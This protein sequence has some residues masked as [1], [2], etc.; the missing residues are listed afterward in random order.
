MEEEEEEERKEGWR[1]GAAASAHTPFYE[2]AYL[3]ERRGGWR[4][5]EEEDGEEVDSCSI[6]VV[7]D[8]GEGREGGRRR[9]GKQELT[10]GAEE[11]GGSGCSTQ[12]LAQIGGI[13]VRRPEGSMSQI[14]SYVCRNRIW[15]V[16]S[17]VETTMVPPVQ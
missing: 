12:Q 1:A 15:D 7:V 13:L 5:E 17:A 9:V 4:I 2:W 16:A 8:R 10:L 6:S 3:P 14:V 11:E